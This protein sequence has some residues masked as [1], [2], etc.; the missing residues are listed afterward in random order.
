MLGLDERRGVPG[1]HRAR[2]S[3]PAPNPF[4]G[5]SVTEATIEDGAQNIGPEQDIGGRPASLTPQ[6]PWA[7]Y[8]GS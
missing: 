5:P 4:I 3:A 7:T 2:F 8:R 1:D 6:V